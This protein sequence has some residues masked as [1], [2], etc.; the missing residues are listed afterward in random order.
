MKP[1]NYSQRVSYRCPP[2][3]YARMQWLGVLLTSS[4]L[5]PGDAVTLEVRGRK[6]GKIRRTPVIWLKHRGDEYLVALAG[7]SNWV[8]NVRAA[9]GLAAIRRRGTHQVRLIELPVEQRPP[10]IDAYL[11]RN[12]RQGTKAGTNE[13]QYYFGLSEKPSLQ[14]IT[15]I[16]EFYPVFKVEPVS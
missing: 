4:G 10:I 9:G 3:F 12:G 5:A 16:A 2:S 1:I 6:S 15:P 14:E 11:K 13:A 8:R 7:E